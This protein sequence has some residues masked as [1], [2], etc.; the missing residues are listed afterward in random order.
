M[1]E[2]K[3]ENTEIIEV[4][5][6]TEGTQ[7]SEVH[8]HFDEKEFVRNRRGERKKGFFAWSIRKRIGVIVAIFAVVYGMISV[9]F[10][11][12]YY[13]GTTINGYECGFKSVEKVT[14]IISEG[15]STYEIRIT[16]RD[17]QEETITA[18][19]V[20]LAFVDDGKVEAIKEEQKPYAWA[21][22][23]LSDWEYADSIT[24][25]VDEESYENTY[26]ALSAFDENLVVA[27]VDAYSEYNKETNTYDIIEEIYGNKVKKKKFYDI[28]RQAIIEQKSSVDI[29][30]EECYKNPTYTKDSEEIVSSN[31]TLN[32]YVSTDIVYDFEDRTQELT[33]KTIHK[34]LTLTDDFKVKLNEEKVADYVAKMAEKYDTVGVER[35]FT[36]IAGNNITVS[37][38]TYGWKIDQEAETAKLIKQIKK[39]KQTTRE[40][41][42]EHIAKSRAENDLGDTY[43]EVD[44]S[45]QHMWFYK[46]GEILVSTDV[47]TG[48]TSNGHGTPTGVYYILYKTTNYTL[49]GDDYSSFVNY[50]MPFT[51]SGVGIHDSSWRSSYG[52][53]IYTYNGSH[54]CVNTPYSAV[55]TIYNN[56]QSTYP[57][58]VHW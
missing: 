31:E 56:I 54:G 46:N 34:W 39:G 12:H 6:E 14:E 43:V 9:F 17:D 41:E 44:L 3:N 22:Y 8:D 5:S 49:T 26:N 52:G 37:G 42:Y 58:V 16:E 51:Q 11:F 2:N 45:S 33:G 19:Q 48:N 53:S 15:V 23:F 29:E 21:I 1:S 38:G 40:L 4:K 28:L 35:S 30:E 18:S 47:V 25:D 36:S 7:E 57:V 10:Y 13:P 55:Q 50:W 20:G 27:P 24:L 32:K